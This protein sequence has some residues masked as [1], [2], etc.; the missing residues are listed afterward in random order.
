[1]L[2]VIDIKKWVIHIIKVFAVIAFIV[3]FK[4]RFEE[5]QRLIAMAFLITIAWFSIDAVINWSSSV[6]ER[7]EA[8]EP[9]KSI[10]DKEHRDSKDSK[11]DK[12]S[13]GEKAAKDG[14][15]AKDDKSKPKTVRRNV[16]YGLSFMPP[17]EWKIPETRPPVCIAEKECPVCPI[18]LGHQDNL[19]YSVLVAGLPET[20]VEV[21]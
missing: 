7:F 8:T 11:D 3:W 12:E 6:V 14:K 18:Y 4:P 9:P 17:D 15:D 20:K 1:M 10:K 2:L 13:K 19:P 5:P 16:D 21:I